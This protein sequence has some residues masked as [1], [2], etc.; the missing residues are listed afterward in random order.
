MCGT[1]LTAVHAVHEFLSCTVAVKPGVIGCMGA[2]G[3]W[4]LRVWG[5]R[6][7]GPVIEKVV[8]AVHER[9]LA[10]ASKACAD[11]WCLVQ[12]VLPGDFHP[13]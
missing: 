2:G 6:L 4:L 10:S 7:C 13:C 11:V 1:S 12:T 3:A 9:R 8:V 5:S